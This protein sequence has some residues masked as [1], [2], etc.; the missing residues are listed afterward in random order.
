MFVHPH[1]R[2][3]VYLISQPEIRLIRGLIRILVLI[4]LLRAR[5][6]LSSPRESLRHATRV[7]LPNYSSPSAKKLQ[8]FCRRDSSP[9]SENLNEDCVSSL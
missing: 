7:R 5:W 8:S 6:Q 2:I 1:K 4:Y 3:T 9:P